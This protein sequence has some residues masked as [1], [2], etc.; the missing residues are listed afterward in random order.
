[1]QDRIDLP[2]YLTRQAMEEMRDLVAL[3]SGASCELRV[4]LVDEPWKGILA[5]AD[6]VDA[7]LIVLGSHGYRGWDR[8]LGTTAGKVANRAHRNVLVVHDN[9][10]RAEFGPR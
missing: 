3:G 9:S 8:V 6:T 7:D 2:A 4:E 1:M 5:A 10:R